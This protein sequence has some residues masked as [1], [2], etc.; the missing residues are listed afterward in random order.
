MI[1]HLYVS[2]TH[3]SISFPAHRD[4]ACTKNM[5][6]QGEETKTVVS[7]IVSIRWEEMLLV[8]VLLITAV[9]F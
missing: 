3:K 5:P 6:Y 1:H 8:L 7:W 2:V 4:I 9:V